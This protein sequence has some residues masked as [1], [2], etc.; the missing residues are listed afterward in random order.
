M[1]YINILMYDLVLFDGISKFD[2]YLQ[3]L[4]T[5]HDIDDVITRSFGFYR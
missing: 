5:R 4:L 3:K 1:R 2:P